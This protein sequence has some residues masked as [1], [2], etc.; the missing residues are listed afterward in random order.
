MKKPA[1]YIG[2][3]IISILLVFTLIGSFAAITVNSVKA[4]KLIA[5]ADENELVSMVRNELERYFNERKNTTGITADIY[6]DNIDE[7]YLS[8]IIQFKINSG[9]STLNGNL[10]SEFD[11]SNTE[12]ENSISDF[13]SEYAE[14]IG[15]EKDNNYD[16]KLINA[17][18]SA[19][20]IIDEYCDVY[21]FGAMERHG[22]LKKAALLYQKLPLIIV[23][24]IIASAALA[25]ILFVINIKEIKEL[26]YWIGTSAVVAGAMGAVPCIYLLATDYF[27]AF[28]IKQP[29]IFT[30]Y[31]TLMKDITTKFMIFSIISVVV[32]IILFAVCAIMSRF[33]KDPEPEKKS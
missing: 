26:A 4:D 19:Y 12:L 1:A 5:A 27:S 22:I 6:M 11:I 28:T 23:L 17:Q 15:Y 14:S 13:F 10:G 8:E 24:C 9:F 16:V 30:A 33:T 7:E 18:K 25:I 31:T 21:K 29:Q 20:T 2:S 3:F 32:G